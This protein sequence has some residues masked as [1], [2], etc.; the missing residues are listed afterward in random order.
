MTKSSNFNP[1]KELAAKI[2]RSLLGE[3]HIINGA[4]EEIFLLSNLHP[5]QAQALE[6][7]K[8]HIA[9]AGG[10][11][12]GKTVA[13]IALLLG[14]IEK[15]PTDDFM[16]ITPT[17]KRMEQST[18]KKWFEMVK[19]LKIGHYLTQKAIFKLH[20]GG[21]VYLR[22]VEENPETVEGATLRA[23]LADE[24]GDMPRKAYLNMKA[25]VSVK[26]GRIFLTSS[27]Y[28]ASWFYEIVN[29]DY[30]GR[31]GDPLFFAK[32][33][34]SRENPSF[35][36][37][38]WEELKKGMDPKDFDREYRGILN[39][40]E[41]LVYELRP[42]NKVE[43]GPERFIEKIAGCDWGYTHPSAIT[44]TAVDEAGD[45]IVVDEFYA[46]KILPNHL[47]ER[48]AELHA[49]HKF[50]VIYCDKRRPELI[51]MMVEAG[52]PAYPSKG[53]D[54]ADGISLVRGYLASGRLKIYSSAC[55]N[56][57]RE[58]SLYHYKEV[59]DPY[60]PEIPVELY[61][62]C[63]DTI[64]MQL[65]SHPLA[66]KSIETTPARQKGRTALDVERTIRRYE[67]GSE[68]EY[69]EVFI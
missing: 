35:S 67:E 34:E 37:E 12:S 17:E 43:R 46:K 19:P 51:G 28:S 9:L 58:T 42:F 65:S 3:V 61:N 5:S 52:L 25:R 59:D 44:V 38:E 21:C 30:F 54:V 16:I 68:D 26:R 22:T 13:G 6:T 39:P 36:S 45:P 57:I 24:A 4:G 11:Q 60:G 18:L 47:I 55:P 2:G 49:K 14:E 64:R 63:W 8:R 32:S 69:E 27:V 7:E 15:Y 10:K 23:I 40:F 56:T 50:N 62:D 41:G 33:F 66:K 48:A 31:Q 20:S 53:N 1:F 29:P